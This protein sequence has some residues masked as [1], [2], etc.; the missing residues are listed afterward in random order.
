MTSRKTWVCAAMSHRR[1]IENAHAAARIEK[2]KASPQLAR[3]AGAGL[4]L[5]VVGREISSVLGDSF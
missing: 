4:S 5:R 1:I 2:W 3:I